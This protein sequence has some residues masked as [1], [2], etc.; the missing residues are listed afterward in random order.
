MSLGHNNKVILQIHA[1]RRH[2]RSTT[3]TPA[4]SKE[5]RSSIP[6]LHPSKIDAETTIGTCSK[7]TECTF[8]RSALV[9]ALE[10]AGGVEARMDFSEL[11]RYTGL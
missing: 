6:Q 8:S 7:G 5:K 10:P 11:L 2:A 1:I 3:H 4:L 9:F